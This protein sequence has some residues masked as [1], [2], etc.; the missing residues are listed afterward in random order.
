MKNKYLEKIAAN[1][2]TKE[3]GSK[4]NPVSMAAGTGVAAAVGHA[5][6]TKAQGPLFNISMST[7]K[8]KSVGD[9]GTVRHMIRKNGTRINMSDNPNVIHKRLFNGDPRDIPSAIKLSRE[10]GASHITLTSR[11]K[12]GEVT[13]TA[14]TLAGL[15]KTNRNSGMSYPKRGN[16]VGP[17][18]ILH[19][20]GHAKDEKG[21]VAKTLGEGE[22]RLIRAS[23]KLGNKLNGKIPG[24]VTKHLHSMSYGKLGVVGGAAALTNEKTQDYATGIAIAGQLPLIRSEAMANVHAAKGIY[25][26]KG[27]KAAA[28]FAIKYAPKQLASYVGGAAPA[29]LGTYAAQKSLQ[30]LRNHNNPDKKVNKS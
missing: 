14:S 28:K 22:R 27:S 2:D 12:K 6:G 17:D 16:V 7:R 23:G 21:I 9:L 19:E 18:T 24:V 3:R 10:T 8:D 13:R 30:Y 26:H 29:V 20:L 1:E 5:A 11:N 4:I 25:H 15:R